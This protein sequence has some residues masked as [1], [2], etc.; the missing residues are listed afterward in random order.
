MITQNTSLSEKHIVPAGQEQGMPKPW[1]PVTH[2]ICNPSRD[3]RTVG[4][5]PGMQ[6]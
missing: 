3:G 6:C 1:G 5:M 2:S 4:Y